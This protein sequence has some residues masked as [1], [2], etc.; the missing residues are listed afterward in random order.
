MIGIKKK[1]AQRSEY[2]FNFCCNKHVKYREVIQRNLAREEAGVRDIV[3]NNDID[4]FF[5]CAE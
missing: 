2:D 5:K 1:M 4:K 3:D